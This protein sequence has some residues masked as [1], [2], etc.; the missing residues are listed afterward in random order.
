MGHNRC[1][2]VVNKNGAPGE[3]CWSLCVS[4]G[5]VRVSVHE[6]LGLGAM[7]VGVDRGDVRGYVSA[8]VV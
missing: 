1:F 5:L 7:L 4:L 6:G 2:Y 8:P 3:L